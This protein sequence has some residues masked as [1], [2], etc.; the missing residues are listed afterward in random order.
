MKL[1]MTL[2]AR[3][4]ADVVDAQIAFHLNA[5]VDFVI[6]TDNL[7]EDGTTDLLE[8]YARDGYLHLI[9]EDSEYLRQADWITRMGR[10]AATDFGADW[11][12][13]SDADEFW[14]PRGG[15]LKEVLESVPA[16]YGIVRALLRQFVPRP[17]DGASFA[18]RMTVRLS[19]AAPINDPTS[20]FRPN[21][22]VVHRADPNVDVSIGAQRLIDSPFVPL[23][24]WYPI[25]FFHF[26][27]R[28]LEQCERKYS[29]QTI[30]AGETPSPYYDRV[31]ALQAEGRLDEFYGSLVVDDEALERGVANGSLV[32]DARLRDALRVLTDGG[33]R[34]FALPAG[35]ESR[36][37]FSRPTVVDEAAYAVD[38]AALGEADVVRL[39]RRLDTLEQRLSQVEARPGARAYRKLRRAA[40]KLLRPNPA[41]AA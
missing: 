38:V 36:L 20:L 28:S 14:W 1:V 5:G 3:D 13:H 25:E 24:G 34:R 17:D 41:E 21:L 2:L 7:S 22:K 31:R 30:A 6:A 37:T 29:H 39:Q 12:I 16:R 15:S 8:S 23:R 40:R 27:I 18:E 33:E 32:V 10:M 35:G 4:E 11:V 26:P 19:A 9:R